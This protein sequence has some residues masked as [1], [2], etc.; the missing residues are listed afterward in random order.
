MNMP[1][2]FIT[3]GESHGPGLTAIISNI[4]AGFKISEEKINF[5][6]ARRQKGYGRGGRMK[7]ETDKVQILAGIRH[8]E[9]TGAPLCLFI[10]NADYAN[11]KDKTPEA[12]TRP[13]PGHADLVGG[14]KYRRKDLRDILERSS[15]RETA[16]RT[17]VGA[18]AIQILEC[19]SIQ[20]A[21]FVKIL[22]GIEVPCF[23][24]KYSLSQ[25]QEITEK[26][27]LRILDPSLEEKIKEK[28]DSAKNLGDTLGGTF[29]VLAQGVPPA[30]GSYAT[31]FSK[32][33]A[34]IAA[35]FLSLQAIKAIEFGLGTQYAHL[36]GSQCHDEIFYTQDQGFFRKTNHAGGIEGG[37]SNGEQIIVKA[38]MKPIPTLMS[39][40]K[41][42]DIVSK[43]PFDAVK[44]RSDV[45]AV[46]AATVV[47]EGIL[48][49][50]ILRA[51]MMRYGQDEKSMM[52]SAFTKE[53]KT[54]FEWL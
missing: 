9:T 5:H 10:P 36:L 11:W 26:S 34:N 16:I 15:A 20:I 1:F 39:P 14:I 6:L 41:S 40:L 32:L 3:A 24:E 49:V 7:I 28:I 21:S 53:N 12:F 4:P 17:A 27:E 19:F 51:L 8:N 46:P 37:M 22:G 44:E 38:T 18:V 45:S 48:A 50:E 47:G 30:L 33:D 25:I 54:R 43:N 42:V 23:L 52:L 13:R 35:G 29:C 2:N 31:S